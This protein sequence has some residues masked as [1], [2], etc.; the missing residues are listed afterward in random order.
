MPEYHLDDSHA[1]EWDPFT[2]AYITAAMWTLQDE[3]G[4]SCDHLSV[5][6]IAPDTIRQAMDDCRNFQNQQAEALT[7]M[8]PSQAG[9]DLWLTRNRHGAGFWDRGHPK[10]VAD[11]LTSAA[12]AYGECDW[13]IGDDGRIYQA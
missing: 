1:H 10:A 6:D 2:R 4:G 12:H 5:A 3:D 13:Y 7:G 8:D 11:A 9:H